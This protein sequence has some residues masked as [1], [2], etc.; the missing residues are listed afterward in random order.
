MAS[1]PSARLFSSS[2]LA[3]LPVFETMISRLPLAS[4]QTDGSLYL[5]C[6]PAPGAFFALEKRSS[7]LPTFLGTGYGHGISIVRRLPLFRSRKRFHPKRADQLRDCSISHTAC[8][9]SFSHEIEP[10]ATSATQL[11][12]S[13]LLWKPGKTR[14]RASCRL[15]WRGSWRHSR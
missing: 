14:N 7:L 5:A 4:F 1:Q 11:L 10:I 3:F 15:M 6:L 12:S 8:R 2:D 9:T 13:Y